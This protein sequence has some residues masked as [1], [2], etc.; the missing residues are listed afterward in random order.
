MSA[1]RPSPS[2]AGWPYALFAT[3]SVVNSRFMYRNASFDAS[4]D[5]VP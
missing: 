2:L 4:R 5:F 3:T 1:R